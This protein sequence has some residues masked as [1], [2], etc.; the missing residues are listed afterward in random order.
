SE[1]STI[2]LEYFRNDSP[3]CDAF[4]AQTL[5]EN[6]NFDARSV[7]GPIRNHRA[8]VKDSRRRISPIAARTAAPPVRIFVQA[9]SQVEPPEPAIPRGK[10]LDG[11]VLIG[12]SS[13]INRFKR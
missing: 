2:P 12:S 10:Y 8:S 4:Q 9:P 7:P 6:I 11:G 3:T 13:V 5:T 1:N